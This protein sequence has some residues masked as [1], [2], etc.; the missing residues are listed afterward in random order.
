MGSASYH[1]AP[2]QGTN[3]PAQV[4]PLRKES[5]VCFPTPKEGTSNGRPYRQKTHPQILGRL[6]EQGV[7]RVSTSA[8]MS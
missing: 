1:N 8:G 4:E 5:G 6:F 3:P 2:H 7:G